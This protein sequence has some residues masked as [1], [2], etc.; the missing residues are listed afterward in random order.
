MAA[1]IKGDLR[2]YVAMTG[3]LLDRL[4]DVKRDACGVR[5]MDEELYQEV[6]ETLQDVNNNYS[7]RTSYSTSFAYKQ[8]KRADRKA[9]GRPMGFDDDE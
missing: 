6:V 3:R 1:D 4:A 5:Q 8:S 2:V 7:E 9:K